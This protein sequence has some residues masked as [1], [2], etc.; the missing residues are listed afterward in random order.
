MAYRR[1]RFVRL[2]EVPDKIDR[3]GL[4]AQPVRIDDAT[5]QQQS[6]IGFWTCLAQRPI[7]VNHVAFFEVVET[8]N[9]G[10][11]IGHDFDVGAVLLERL[12]WFDQFHLFHAV[13]RKH[14][15]LA[16]LKPK[17]HLA[18]PQTIREANLA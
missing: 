4:E 15:Q 8:L 9:F 5:G 14:R 10:R 12:D 11:L 18:S 16:V 13:S 1:N 6:V 7:N 17:S 3:L 2:H